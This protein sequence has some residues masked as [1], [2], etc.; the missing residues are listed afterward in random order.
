[1]AL[2]GSGFAPVGRV[3]EGMSVVD[4]LHSGYGEGA[5]RGMGPDQGRAQLQ[6]NAYFRRDFPQLDYVKKATL[7]P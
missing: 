6:G 5:P 1:V 4:S 7:V 2:D 3:I